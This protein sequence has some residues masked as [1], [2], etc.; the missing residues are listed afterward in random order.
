MSKKQSEKKTPTNPKPLGVMVKLFI[1]VVIIVVAVAFF[2][3]QMKTKPLAKRKPVDSPDK[4]VQVHVAKRTEV[5]VVLDNIQGP[6]MPAQT[7]TLSPQVSGLIVDLN[8]DVIP[9]GIVSKDQPLLRIDDS[10][11]R[12]ALQQRQ[13]DVARA[14]LNLE[15]EQGNQAI[16]LQEYEML[17]EEIP[18]QDRALILR[19]PHLAEAQA[20]LVAAR[21]AKSRAELDV[22]RCQVT[23]P[24]NAVIREKKV[25][26]GTRVSPGTNLVS[27]AGTDEYWVEASVMVRDLK[28]IK[29]PTG[30]DGVGSRVKILDPDT[31]GDGLFREGRIIRLLSDIESEGLMARLLISIQDPL[32]LKPENQGKPV[33]LLGS[34]VDVEIQGEILESVI[35]LQREWL[36]EGTHVWILTEEKTLKIQEVTMSFQGKEQVCVVDGLADGDRVVVTDIAAPV[37]GMSLQL[38]G[39]AAS[40]PNQPVSSQQGQGE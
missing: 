12:L 3:R 6:V 25:D 35:P 15:L 26:L 19:E 29:A 21:A 16:A 28:W 17:G 38:A 11:Y 37:E 24:F 34:K 13:S 2:M 1:P 30:Q 18:D 40:D 27:L 10:D 23:S 7:V 36:R 22:S 33:V 5:R 32:A 9:G 20:A 4:Q 8:S 14:V 39:E 31:W